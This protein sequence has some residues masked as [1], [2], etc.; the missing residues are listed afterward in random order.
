MLSKQLQ[1]QKQELSEGYADFIYKTNQLT[2]VPKE[3]SA[4]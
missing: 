2:I 1:S 4:M 3:T